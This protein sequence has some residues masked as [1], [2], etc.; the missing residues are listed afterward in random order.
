MFS[1]SKKT[2][3]LL[4]KGCVAGLA[5]YACYKLV[6]YFLTDEAS[7]IEDEARKQFKTFRE[8]PPPKK[9][10]NPKGTKLIKK[11]RELFRDDLLRQQQLA[12]TTRIEQAKQLKEELER[13]GIRLHNQQ[14]R[15]FSLV[16]QKKTFLIITAY[17]RSKAL[18]LREINNKDKEIR[19]LVIIY[20]H[21]RGASLRNARFNCRLPQPATDSD[22]I[23]Y[24]VIRLVLSRLEK[25]DYLGSRKRRR[26]HYGRLLLKYY[27][28]RF[29]PI[30]NTSLIL[31]VNPVNR[32]VMGQ[33]ECP[34]TTVSSSSSNKEIVKKQLNISFANIEEVNLLACG[35]P[36]GVSHKQV[37]KT[38][39]QNCQYFG[40]C[41]TEGTVI[42]PKG[43]LESFPFQW[44]GETR[45]FS[46]AESERL[47]QLYNGWVYPELSIQM[48]TPLG[49]VFIPIYSA[50][51]RAGMDWDSN[52]HNMGRST[53]I[54]ECI[55][56]SKIIWNLGPR[57]HSANMVFMS[58]KKQGLIIE[59]QIFNELKRIEDKE[60]DGKPLL[61]IGYT[62]V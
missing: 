31:S 55:L 24:A 26:N 19:R 38:W 27:L 21:L 44:I 60:F 61:K 49:Q 39:R 3:H 2:Q 20:A 28:D 47:L 17:F 42:V 46:L 18:L 52:I 1:V 62:E 22:V 33:L 16:A 29:H 35:Y 57:H 54:C 58:E 53:T 12:A 45:I 23:K 5:V 48:M 56:P 11:A 10:E 13:L 6:Q 30:N 50:Y 25:Y 14:V 40:G 59:S 43:Y 32:P 36:I 9:D 7:H 34:D 15:H 41:D 8:L 37:I 4:A 51:V